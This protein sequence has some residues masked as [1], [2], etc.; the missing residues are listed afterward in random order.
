MDSAK[1][2]W[3]QAASID[4]TGYYSERSRDLLNNALPLTPPEVVDLG[5]DRQSELHQAELW[6]QAT[7]DYPTGTD[8]SSPGPLAGDPRF[9]RGLE[10]W[11]MGLYDQAE[12]EFSGLRIALSDPLLAYRLAVYLSDGHVAR[13]SQPGRYWTWQVWMMRAR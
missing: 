5:G 2:T 11:Q 10:F 8:Y 1:A 7:F 13:Q 9:I 6:M 3:Q 12:A 4:P